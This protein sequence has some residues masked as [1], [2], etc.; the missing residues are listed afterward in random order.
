M[1]VLCFFKEIDF[2]DFLKFKK[3]DWKKYNE[4]RDMKCK[5]VRKIRTTLH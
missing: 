4:D 5:F 3:D 1:I 2:V